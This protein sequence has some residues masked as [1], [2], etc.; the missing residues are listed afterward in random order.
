MERRR[1]TRAELN[2]LD[3]AISGI[4]YVT[5]RNIEY[6]GIKV[7]EGYVFDGVTVKAPFTVIFNSTDL[8]KGLRASCFHDWICLHK[9]EYSRT[10]ATDVLVDLWKQDGLSPVKCWIVK[11]S[12][13][14]YQWLKGGWKC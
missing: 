13:N 8:R 6:D 5:R 4:N 12:V 9:S 11:I 10:Y 2:S 14:F 7:P 1:L 3:F